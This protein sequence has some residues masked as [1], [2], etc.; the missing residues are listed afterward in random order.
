MRKK[1]A[2]L[3]GGG[4]CAG[5]NPALKWIV[6]TALDPIEEE[7]RGA[8]YEIIGI[9]EGWKG[10]IK[11]DP[12]TPGHDS[13]W[14]EELTVRRVR[15]WD[16]AG[17]TWLG[18]S[19]TNPFDKKNN[20]HATVLNNLKALGVDVLIAIGGEDTLG[21][22][23]RL[24]KKGVNTVGIPKTIDKDL[25]GTD[26]SLGFQTALEVITSEIDSIR[27]TAGSH[28]R[29][30]VV[31]TMGRHAGWLAL[32]GGMAGGADIILI[33]EHD[34]DPQRVCDLLIE[35]RNKGYRYSIVVIAEGAKAAELEEA[36]SQDDIDVDS[37]GHRTLGGVGQWL[38]KEIVEK[39]QLDTRAV[40]LSHLQR[41][42]LPSAYDRL[43]GRNFG[44]AAVDMIDKELF[45]QLVAYK[46]GVVTYLP[47]TAALD[48]LNVVDVDEYYDTE[49]YHGRRKGILTTISPGVDIPEP[50]TA[51]E[52][53]QAKVKK[54]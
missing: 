39:T 15:N 42:G 31:E 20:Q 34:Y 32:E 4:D 8:R 54:K 11:Y 23:H 26:Y 2:V 5:L 50:D 14:I 25:S 41:G 6:T 13:P 46:D 24:W 53:A 1:I 30:F 33:P 45:G 35:R 3:T 19:R 16:R 28:G 21:V 27:T 44:I 29:V 43:M 18:S 51:K 12:S 36:I 22:A 40:V 10:L 48:T 17:G 7:E 52:K 49:M 37:F 47:L 38:R 9:R